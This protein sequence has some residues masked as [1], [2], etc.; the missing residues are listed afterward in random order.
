MPA[1]I[2]KG[3]FGQPAPLR[4]GQAVSNLAW[5]HFPDAARA[6]ELQADP[7]YRDDQTLPFLEALF[8]ALR[9]GMENP[10]RDGGEPW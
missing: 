4:L 7:H 10:P 6:A 2:D 9:A 1:A 3:P 5:K 8:R